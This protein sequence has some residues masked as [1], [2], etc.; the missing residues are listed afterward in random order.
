MAPAGCFLR[1]HFG[2]CCRLMMGHILADREVVVVGGN[3]VVAGRVN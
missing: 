2:L 1:G 3:V